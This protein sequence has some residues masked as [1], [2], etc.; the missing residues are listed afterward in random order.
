MSRIYGVGN[1]TGNVYDPNI[2]DKCEVGDLSGNHGKLQGTPN[3]KVTVE[4]TDQYISLNDTTTLENGVI[5]RAVVIHQTY[6]LPGASPSR[7]ACA[8]IIEGNR[9][10]ETKQKRA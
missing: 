7:I 1:A 4:Y 8:N 6:A 3:D 5:V 10:Q 9:S 2:P